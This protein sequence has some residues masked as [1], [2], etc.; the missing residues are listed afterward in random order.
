MENLLLAERAWRH[1]RAR[2]EPYLDR[3]RV[4][5][6]QKDGSIAADGEQAAGTPPVQLA[7][8]SGEVLQDGLI[9]EFVKAIT[10]S[11]D[12]RWLQTVSAGLDHPM[13][14]RVVE[15]GARLANSD[16]QAPAIAEYVVGSVIDHYQDFA[17][18]REAQASKRW[19]PVP[20]RQI[21]GTTWLIVG[22]G[23]IGQRVGR[24][25][26]A[27]EGEVI[28]VKRRAGE[29]VHADRIVTFDDL[30]SHIPQAD[31]IVISCALTEET[32]GLVDERL[33]ANAKP[34]S[35]LVNIA[36]GDIVDEHALLQALGDR[37][38]CAILDVFG[39]EPLPEDSPFWTH[40]RV[41]LTP[42]A[43]HSGD[44]TYDRGVDLFF[45]N[46]EAYLAGRPLR[47]EVDLSFF[48]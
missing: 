21:Y 15:G 40:A 10:A 18:R 47:N 41:L 27:F 8:M 16:A 28:G 4:L 11:E 26:R 19:Q 34:G 23:N 43:S 35:V 14:R 20:F 9:T 38:E 25:V 32:R 37:L 22:F 24:I 7:W 31:V 1:Q 39:Q 48:G 30:A 44:A 45:E 5:R 13:F 42:H 17:A 12:F 29:H 6:L 36:R 46:L 3:I 2:L 33:L